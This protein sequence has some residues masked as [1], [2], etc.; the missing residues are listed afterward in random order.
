MEILLNTSFE[1]EP[2][3]ISKIFGVLMSDNQIM[4]QMNNMMTKEHLREIHECEQ[5]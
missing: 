4:S 2:M 3:A 5:K 1:A